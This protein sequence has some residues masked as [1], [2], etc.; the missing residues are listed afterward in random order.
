MKIKDLIEMEDE[1]KRLDRLIREMEY[2]LEQFKLADKDKE[3]MAQEEAQ[4]KGY[5]VGSTVSLAIIN[6]GKE[7]A[8]HLWSDVTNLI[9]EDFEEVLNK[10][11]IKLREQRDQLEV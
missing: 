11:I 7:R 4:E 5:L 10:H 6:S 1:C 3:E 2:V 8:I 9:R